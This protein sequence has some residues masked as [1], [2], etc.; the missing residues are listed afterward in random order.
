MYGCCREAR[1]AGVGEGRVKSEE[2][3]VKRFGGFAPQSYI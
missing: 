2:R 1:P 3:R